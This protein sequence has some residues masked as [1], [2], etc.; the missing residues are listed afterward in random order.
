MLITYKMDPLCKNNIFISKNYKTENTS[1][2][3]LLQGV[4]SWAYVKQKI[5]V[6]QP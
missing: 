6:Y 4:K 5:H 3:S 1:T 2:S